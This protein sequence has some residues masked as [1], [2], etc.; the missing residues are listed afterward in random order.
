MHCPTSPRKL[1]TINEFHDPNHLA[2]TPYVS[3]TSHIMLCWQY[4]EE[5]KA[6]YNDESI[7]DGIDIPNSRYLE[8]LEVSI[9][10]IRRLLNQFFPH[11]D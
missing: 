10:D 2:N 7:C 6:R 9:E 8:E 3:I 4:A 1:A 11:S 5:L